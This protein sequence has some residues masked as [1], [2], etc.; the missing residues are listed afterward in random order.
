[1]A[2]LAEL[3]GMVPVKFERLYRYDAFTPAVARRGQI[4]RQKRAKM[5]SG[6]EGLSLLGICFMFAFMDLNPGMMGDKGMQAAYPKVL[7]VLE[8]VYQVA[9][10]K[11]LLKSRCYAHDQPGR[12]SLKF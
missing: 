10:N 5:S 11:I 2:T 12:P 3:Y 4:A 1:M 6:N 8:N 9:Y 7:P